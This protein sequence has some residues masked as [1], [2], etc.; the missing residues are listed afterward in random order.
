[1]ALYPSNNRHLLAHDAK[2]VH[3]PQ[4]LLFGKNIQKP[5]EGFAR[6]RTE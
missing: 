6:S 3:P 5:E 1:M 2:G 4:R